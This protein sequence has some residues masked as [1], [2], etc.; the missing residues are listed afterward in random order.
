M[1]DHFL[2]VLTA[3]VQ[4]TRTLEDFASVLVSAAVEDTL[5]CVARDYGHEYSTMIE[6]YRD[7]IT[8]RH[9]NASMASGVCLGRNAN[10]KPCGKKAVCRGYCRLH[11]TQGEEEDLKRRKTVA[12]KNAV[13]AAGVADLYPY[14]SSSS[15][16]V[17][18]K[19]CSGML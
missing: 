13:R 7:A 15:Y 19:Y 1:S 17:Q 16:C 10:G 12:Y 9:T 5:L 6:A 11:V 2:R 18:K 8:Q 4:G 3:V 14:V